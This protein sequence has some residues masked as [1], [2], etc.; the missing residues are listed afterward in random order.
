MMERFRQFWTNVV[1]PIANL[2]LRLG[3]S[4]DA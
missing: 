4:P 3:V 1:T 2:L